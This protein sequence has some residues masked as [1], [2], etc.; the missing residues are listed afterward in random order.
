MRHALRILTLGLCLGVA[1]L[2]A[3]VNA[4]ATT[5]AVV[6]QVTALENQGF[7][8]LTSRV[9]K[10]LAAT[11]SAAN[12]GNVEYSESWLAAQPKASGDAAWECL[13]E[14]LYF[15]ARG[16][17]ARGLFAVAEVIMNRV[18]SAA[19]PDSVCGVINQGTGQRFRCQFTYTCDG[20]EER[21]TEPAAWTRVGKVARAMLD[22][23]PRAL[24]KGA[25]YY[26]ATWVSPDWSRKFERTAAIGVH[27]FYRPRA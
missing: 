21:I 5:D 20:R 24:T 22:G 16:E 12:T 9:L 2:T 17:N 15:E 8:A 7:D 26:H 1:G 19:F 27:F 4:Q 3:P 14:A 13:T 23:A 10:A 6:N 11:P 25:T 18:D